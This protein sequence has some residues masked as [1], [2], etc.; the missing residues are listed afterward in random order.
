M[1]FQIK[2]I[3]DK[4]WSR[5]I[6]IIRL[7]WIH[8]LNLIGYKIFSSLHCHL[9]VK[10]IVYTWLT[11][12][13]TDIKQNWAKLYSLVWLYYAV[14]VIQI[15]FWWFMVLGWYK[16]VLLVIIKMFYTII[17]KPVNNCNRRCKQFCNK[18]VRL[19]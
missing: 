4:L 12:T 19:E 18:H 17:G 5:S 9:V 1:C 2:I 3:R 8:T 15:S 13:F 6:G 10:L 11:V 14:M 16:L 7:I